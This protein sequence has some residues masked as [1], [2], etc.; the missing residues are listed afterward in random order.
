MYYFQE[1]TQNTQGVRPAD[2]N[3]QD[4][5]QSDSRPEENFTTKSPVT[6]GPSETPRKKVKKQGSSPSEISMAIQQLDKIAQSASAEKPYDLFGKFVAS[7]LRQL[8]QRQAILLQQEIHECIIRGK[9]SSFENVNYPNLNSRS[10][11]VVDN[12][13]SPLSAHSL[14]SCTKSEYL[15]EDDLDVSN[16]EQ[17]EQDFQNYN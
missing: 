9:L 17:F 15:N 3:H 14:V 12:A 5:L 6:K 4:V 7:E 13:S 16:V 1:L 11:T 10:V 8:P 2:T